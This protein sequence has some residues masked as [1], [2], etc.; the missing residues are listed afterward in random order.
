MSCASQL[1]IMFGVV[2]SGRNHLTK[3]RAARVSS[4][5]RFL[6]FL[7]QQRFLFNLRSTMGPMVSLLLGR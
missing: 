1:A 2:E 7:D 4:P 3:M 5:I 6:N